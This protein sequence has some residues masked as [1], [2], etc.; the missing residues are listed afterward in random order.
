MSFD[1]LFVSEVDYSFYADRVVFSRK[2]QRREVYIKF[3]KFKPPSV[4]ASVFK[5][6]IKTDGKYELPT[7]A[8]RASKGLLWRDSTSE[9]A[10][11]TCAIFAAT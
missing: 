1:K 11:W 4:L 10:R 5:K 6:P 3:V 2:I 9:A 8:E 7:D